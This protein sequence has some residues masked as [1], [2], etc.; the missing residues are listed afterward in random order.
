MTEVTAVAIDVGTKIQSVRSLQVLLDSDLAA[1][2]RRLRPRRSI[3]RGNA[4]PNASR[5]TLPFSCQRRSSPD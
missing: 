2:L 4:V 5:R 1:D 3:W